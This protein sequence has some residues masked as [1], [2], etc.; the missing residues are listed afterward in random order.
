[1]FGLRPFNEDDHL[2]ARS[3][4][5]EEPERPDLAPAPRSPDYIRLVSPRSVAVNRM[6]IQHF[7]EPVPVMKPILGTREGFLFLKRE[8]FL[9]YYLGVRSGRLGNVQSLVHLFPPQ[10]IQTRGVPCSRGRTV[11]KLY[12]C[13]AVQ[14]V[15]GGPP[16]QTFPGEGDSKPVFQQAGMASAMAQ[17]IGSVLPFS[18]AL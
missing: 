16:D 11:M 5:C 18:S 6:H 10:E 7:V 2:G 4:A 3:C 14:R 17:K 8:G 9:M 1:V 15:C 13:L 12:N